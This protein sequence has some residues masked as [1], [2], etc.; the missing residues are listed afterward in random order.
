MLTLS[1]ASPPALAVQPVLF[2][3]NDTAATEIYTLSLP[4]ALPISDGLRLRQDLAGRN[5]L[6]HL[7][8]QERR[9]RHPQSGAAQ[10][11]LRL[12][13]CQFE[14]RHAFARRKRRVGLHAESRP[15]PDNPGEAYCGPVERSADSRSL[16]HYQSGLHAALRDQSDDTLPQPGV[17]RK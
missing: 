12:H 17:W 8:V 4:D 13:D 16:A 3:F 7:Q 11:N 15:L 10:T 9:R 1:R 6:R 2:F 14:A 5:R